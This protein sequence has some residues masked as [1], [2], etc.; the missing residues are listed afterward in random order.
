MPRKVNDKGILINANKKFEEIKQKLEEG[1][2]VIILN[3]KVKEIEKEPSKTSVIYWITFD[4]N[5]SRAF[6][7]SEFIRLTVITEG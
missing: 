1:K 7:L 5:T 2:L 4:D 3:K 6:Y